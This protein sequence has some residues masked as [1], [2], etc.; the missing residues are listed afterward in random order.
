[1]EAYSVVEPVSCWKF[2]R[3]ILCKSTTN[4][5]LDSSMKENVRVF[6]RLRPT[7]SQDLL[8]TIQTCKL[9]CKSAFETAESVNLPNNGEECTTPRGGNNGAT[10]HLR[11]ILKVTVPRPTAT[12]G[13]SS[14]YRDSFQFQFDRIFPTTC[15]QE[16]LFEHVARPLVDRALEGFNGTLF[17]YG[18]TGS[19]KTYTITGPLTGCTSPQC[20][21]FGHGC[22]RSDCQHGIIPRTVSHIFQSIGSNSEVSNILSISYLEIYN[23][24]GYD[25]LHPLWATAGTTSATADELGLPKIRLLEDSDQNVHVGNLSMHTVETAQ[26]AMTLLQIGQTNRARAETPVNP[27]S[28]RSHCIFTVIIKRR[29]RDSAVVK[30]AKLHIVDLAG[31]ER[32]WKNGIGGRCLTEAKY[33]NLSLHHLEQVIGALGEKN[34]KHIPYRNSLLTSILKD[35]LGGNCLTSMIATCSTDTGNIEESLSTCRFSQRVALIDNQAVVNENLDP[36]V[37]LQ[38]LRK[39]LADLKKSYSMLL[40][41]HT[42]MQGNLVAEMPFESSD[43][44]VSG[45]NHPAFL[46]QRLSQEEKDMCKRLV[47]EYLAA[48]TAV[49]KSFDGDTEE[50]ELH[51]P[52]FDWRKVQYLFRILKEMIIAKPRDAPALGGQLPD[53]YRQINEDKEKVTELQKT[54]Q[55]RDKELA[56]LCKLL[57]QEKKRFDRLT[58]QKSG[59][60]QS[61]NSTHASDRQELA[62]VDHK[63]KSGNS[64]TKAEITQAVYEK[65]ATASSPPDIPCHTDKEKWPEFVPIDLV[66]QIQ[67]ASANKT[68]LDDSNLK[69]TALMSFIQSHPEKDRLEQLK[70]SLVSRVDQ[71]RHLG[72]GIR[73]LQSQLQNVP[74]DSNLLQSTEHQRDVAL[75]QI[76]LKAML[77]QLRSLKSEVDVLEAETKARSGE[78]Q[79]QF[80]QWWK[81]LV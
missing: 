29:E 14:H 34:R 44:D 50:Y 5:L 75:K 32:V 76:R 39:Q 38:L 68:L 48:E 7:S 59:R 17:A 18:Q 74:A 65:K 46:T 81:S 23:E 73:D 80:D 4:L 69:R 10:S 8:D 35:S 71:A 42:R 31:S 66:A 78:I 25:L 55:Q 47:D 15:Y 21:S 77:E 19:G 51:V 62:H 28:T 60:V 37:E 6:V 70:V 36:A 30:M 41:A 67:L 40:N 52:D 58:E 72:G 13:T 3:S 11:Q 12:D 53:A 22:S 16:D 20:Q 1:M 33:I 24:S 57:R 64:A 61:E 9:P 2:V 63:E 56:I 49:H 45:S 27:A 79:Q 26:E 43:G 54:L